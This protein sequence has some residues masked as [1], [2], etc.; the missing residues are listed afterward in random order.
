MRLFRIVKKK[1]WWLNLHG[2]L[3]DCFADATSLHILEPCNCVWDEGHLYIVIQVRMM[4][5]LSLIV[6]NSYVE[7]N[8]P[9]CSMVT[10]CYFTQFDR[11]T[12]HALAD[13]H[14]SR[15]YSEHD[16]STSHQE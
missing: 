13:S 10:N 3:H 4:S 2:K 15:I 16:D 7:R 12:F 14:D 8:S 1:P 6:Y 11:S 5:K 9:L